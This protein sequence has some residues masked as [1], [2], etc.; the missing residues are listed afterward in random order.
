MNL[1]VPIKQVPDTTDV[2]INP[3]TNTLIRD[4]VRSVTNPFD[5]F[6]IE[7]ALRLK[8][9]F[10]G[11]VTVVTMGPPQAKKVLEEAM[12]MGVDDA[13]LLS[14]RAFAGSDTLATSYV[15]AQAIKRIGDFDLIVCGKQASDGDTAQVGPG[16]A[17]RLKLPHASFV[18]KVRTVEKRSVVV[19]RSAD[20]GIEVVKMP[21]PSLITVTKEINAPRHTSFAGKFR[22]KRTHVPMWGPKDIGCDEAIVGLEG[23]PTWVDRIFT[24][25]MKKGCL[26][27]DAT[28]ENIAKL[29]GEILKR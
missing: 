20:D 16:I 15:I 24:P 28:K 9:R 7:E 14:N 1:I 29:A 8:E 21:L 18:R 25:P 2:K 3:Q 13:V 22:A 17:V 19:E 23:S 11:K 12:A 27:M 10:G 26:P 5:M 4:G 6:A